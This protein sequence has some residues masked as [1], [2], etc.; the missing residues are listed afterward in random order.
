MARDRV[1]LVVTEL[2]GGRILY[3]SG[4][5]SHEEL[6]PLEPFLVQL[7]VARRVGDDI[8]APGTLPTYDAPRESV[9]APTV[10]RLVHVDLDRQVALWELESHAGA[11]ESPPASTD[12]WT[13]RSGVVDQPRILCVDNDSDGLEVLRLTLSS[14]AG[15]QFL[16]ATNGRD[17]LALVHEMQ[18][19]VLL[20][21]LQL[22]DVSGVTVVEICR[23][24]PALASIPVIVLTAD[25][26]TATRRAIEALGVAHLA[27]KP[28]DLVELRAVVEGLLGRD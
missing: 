2:R 15:V 13:E 21:D 6:A 16:A 20:V 23:R 25:A 4:S 10:C 12:H 9:P 22:P 7:A 18:P 8:V 24:S 3:S 19:S 28:F 27:I 5:L 14:L 1:T 11:L 26:A 17:G